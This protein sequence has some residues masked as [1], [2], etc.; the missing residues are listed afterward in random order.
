M[1]NQVERGGPMA[2]DLT[3]MIDGFQAMAWLEQ[4][5]WD[6]GMDGTCRSCSLFAGQ[7]FK[8][9]SPAEAL[10]LRCA[11][12]QAMQARVDAAIGVIRRHRPGS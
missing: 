1:T 4:H 6:I 7:L 12:A 9:R 2:D 5:S 8:G 11:Q 3:T 10:P